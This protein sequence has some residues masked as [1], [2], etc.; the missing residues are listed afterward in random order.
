MDQWDRMQIGH[1]AMA[2]DAN[3]FIPLGAL[4]QLS[5]PPLAIT[6]GSRDPEWINLPCRGAYRYAHRPVLRLPLDAGTAATA[7]RW[8]R[9]HKIDDF[10]VTP[11]VLLLFL[12]GFLLGIWGRRAGSLT[13]LAALLSSFVAVALAWWSGTTERSLT[14]RCHPEMVGRLGIYIPGIPA[15]VAREW[16][17]RNVDVQIVAASP[18]WRRYPRWVYIT[19]S[20]LCAA[21]GVGIFS[22]EATDRQAGINL[23]AAL[24]MTFLFGIAIAFAVKALPP[25]YIAFIRSNT[26]N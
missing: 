22:V 1:A 13:Y 20:G 7:R 12:A 24:T 17:N 6:D 4:G 16:T 25:G 8:I 15:A 10:L 26:T 23:A 5:V 9:F 3:L 14:V 11:A 18:T 21:V 19:M 2:S